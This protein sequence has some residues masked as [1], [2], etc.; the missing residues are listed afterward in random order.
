MPVPLF[1]NLRLFWA[2]RLIYLRGR[3]GTWLETA[4][5]TMERVL[6]ACRR[7]LQPAYPERTTTSTTSS[8]ATDSW[9]LTTPT[10]ASKGRYRQRLALSELATDSA[11][12]YSANE[13]LPINVPA[14]T[15][16]TGR[17]RSQPATRVF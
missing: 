17:P 7:A 9:T 6:V 13:L 2:L 1:M 14:G 3:C 8:S 12:S 4:T 10:R 5:K 11:H 15:C 16:H